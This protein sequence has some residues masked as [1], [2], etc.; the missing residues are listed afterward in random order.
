MKKLV[1]CAICMFFL[2]GLCACSDG[3]SK[4]SV[5][6]KTGTYV[7]QNANKTVILPNVTLDDKNNFTFTYSALS[8]NIPKG[9]YEVKGNKLILSVDIEDGESIS[10]VF[11]IDKGNLVYQKGQSTPLPAFAKDE[12]YD[13]AIFKYVAEVA[14]EK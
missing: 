7:L 12:V 2:Y 3:E 4:S 13:G 9:S 14:I 1:V 11:N 8:S 10:Y 5:D 6:I